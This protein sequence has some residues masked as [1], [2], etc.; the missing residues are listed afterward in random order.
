MYAVTLPGIGKTAAPALPEKTPVSDDRRAGNAD[1][2]R[3]N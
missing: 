1:L 3:C 2:P